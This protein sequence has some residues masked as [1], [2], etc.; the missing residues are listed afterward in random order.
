M[1]IVWY[2]IQLNPMD[3]LAADPFFAVLTGTRELCGDL[4]SGVCKVFFQAGLRELSPDGVPQDDLQQ[5]R[6]G[7]LERHPRQIS[8]LLERNSSPRLRVPF[9]ANRSQSKSLRGVSELSAR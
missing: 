9:P 7:A 8:P 4:G 6:L 2:G 5:S 1:I 3:C